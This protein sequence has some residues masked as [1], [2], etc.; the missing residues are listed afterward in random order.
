MKKTTI[1]TICLLLILSGFNLALAD[2][3]LP[4]LTVSQVVMPARTQY[5]GSPFNA[6]DLQVKVENLNGQAADNTKVDFLILNSA[7]E[8]VCQGKGR[9]AGTLQAWRDISYTLDRYE[10]INCSNLEAGEHYFQA[11]VDYSGSITEANE[12]NNYLEREFTVSGAAGAPAISNLIARITSVSNKE[13]SMY[14][15]LAN[16]SDNSRIDFATE[17]F[18]GAQ[19]K[20]DSVKAV[21]TLFKVNYYVT[22]S[23]TEKVAYRYRASMGDSNLQTPGQIYILMPNNP[24]PA[25]NLPYIQNLIEVKNITDTGA[26]ISW[27]TNKDSSSKVTYE[28]NNYLVNGSDAKIVEKSE[29]STRE[30]TISLTGLVPNTKYYYKVE[31]AVG[32]DSYSFISYFWTNEKMFASQAAQAPVISNL[33]VG[34]IASASAAVTWETDIESTSKITYRAN[35]SDL[36]GNE[37]LILN[38]SSLTASHSF[39]LTGLVAN[40]KYYYKIESTANGLTSENSGD[41]T[42][43]EASQE[44]ACSGIASASAGDLIKIEGLSSVYYYGNDCKRYVFPNAKTYFSWYSDY[45]GVKTVSQNDLL[46]ISIGGN[47]TYRPGVK[48][49]KIT[50]NPKVYA[51]TKKGILRWI[52][53]EELAAALYGADWN[54]KIDDVPDG[55]FTNYTVGDSIGNVSDYNIESAKTASPDINT[56]KGL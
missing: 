20:Y 45:S 14:Y 33:T 18:W 39:N 48:M 3:V 28:P 29:D 17:D 13:V 12:N 15:D 54:T 1:I 10:F 35:N 8:A 16:P 25:L 56:D 55:F 24:S 9:I 30:H 36:T 5:S 47:I 46:S 31:S 4:D 27:A 43:L 49:V 34:N 22:A 32:S 40:T 7:K 19:K 11:A 52:E 44:P 53:T 6:L 42:T 23:S 50:T 38:S 51:V 21:S 26:A 2:D 41:F 37:A